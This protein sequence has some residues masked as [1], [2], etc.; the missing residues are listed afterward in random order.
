MSENNISAVDSTGYS[1]GLVH[2][3]LDLLI[4]GQKLT[5]SRLRTLERDESKFY[6][7]IL[8]ISVAGGAVSSWIATHLTIGAAWAADALPSVSAFPLPH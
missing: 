1:L 5:E 7:V 3:K 6:G 8:A 2:G 4:E